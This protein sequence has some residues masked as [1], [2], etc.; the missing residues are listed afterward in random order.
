MAES[1][2]KEY[3]T[4]EQYFFKEK[5]KVYILFGKYDF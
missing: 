1:L 2:D 5:K 4:E 3:R